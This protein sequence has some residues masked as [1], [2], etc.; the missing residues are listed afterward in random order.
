[1]AK[2]QMRSIAYGRY[3]MEMRSG[4]ILTI[5]EGFTKLIGYTEEDVK[6]IR[7]IFKNWRNSQ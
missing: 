3:S 2:S 7:K 4:K 1:M 5:D 6:I